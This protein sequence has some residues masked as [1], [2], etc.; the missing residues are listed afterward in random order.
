MVIGIPVGPVF[1][2]RVHDHEEL[3]HAGDQRCL[4]SLTSIDQPVIKLPNFLVVLSGRQGCHVEGFS[5]RRAAAPGRAL[6]TVFAAVLARRGNA[7][8]FS[9]LSAVCLS[10]FGEL[11]HENMGSCFCH[12]WNRAEK[13]LLLMPESA[14]LDSF[15][16]LTF[17]LFKALF[18]K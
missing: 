2:H 12:A 6:S 8:E 10:K 17:G 9:N 18:Q 13:L 11:G 1:H 5:D 14:V 3:P 15:F 7:C 16:D 4:L